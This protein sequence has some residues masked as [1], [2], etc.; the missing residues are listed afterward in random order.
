MPGEKKLK[1][2]NTLIFWYKGTRE[3]QERVLFPL[4]GPVVS[5]VSGKC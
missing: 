3:V 2:D 4:G 1:I 5:V